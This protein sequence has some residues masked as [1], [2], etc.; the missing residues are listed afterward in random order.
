MK[1][2]SCFV[3]VSFL[4]TTLSCFGQNTLKNRSD[5][6]QYQ[7]AKD[8]IKKEKY[9][10]A[11]P[12]FVDIAKNNLSETTRKE[13]SFY[14][15]LCALQLE[16]PNA[17]DL[18]L[19]FLKKSPND[20]LANRA[21]YELGTHYYRKQKYEKTIKYLSETDFSF[22]DKQDSYEVEFSLAYS[23]FITKDLDNA[24]KHFEA[25]KNN[26]H[27]YKYAANYYS[28][29]IKFKKD[30]YNS[31][32]RDLK[33]AEE[34]G[35]YKQ[36]VPYMIANI[37][38]KQKNYKTLVDYT[39]PII[40]SNDKVSAKAEIVELTAESYF[41]MKDY[42]KAATYF[43]AY[44]GTKKSADKEINYRAGYANLKDGKTQKSID[45]FKE[46]ADAKDSLGQYAS[47]Y[48]GQAYIAE[49]NKVYA[50]AAL[51]EASKSTF[52]LGIREAALFDVARLNYELEQFDKAIKA[53][54]EFDK[55]FP[56]SVRKEKSQEL[57]SDAFVYSNN[58]N[59]ALVYLEA[60]TSLTPKM[61]ENYQHVAYLKAV[62]LY[63]KRAFDQAVV[64]F[65]KSLKYPIN[66]NIEAECQYLQGETYSFNHNWQAAINA[67]AKVFQ[68]TS[69]QSSLF[70]KSRYGIGY[71]YF[72][73]NEYKKAKDH[74]AKFL[75]SSEAKTTKMYGDAFLRLGDCYYFEKNYDEAIKQYNAAIDRK[76]AGADY[77]F[78]QLG[79]VYAISDKLE[80][81]DESFAFLEKNF[82]QSPYR[83][84]ASYNRAR[85]AFE[86]GKYE[87]AEILYTSYINKYSSDKMYSV[88]L[89]KRGKTYFN[90]G[91]FQKSLADYDLLLDDFCQEEVAQ[92][93]LSGA[94]QALS[95]LSRS[96][97][98]DSRLN[99]FETCNP[100]NESIEKIRFE[101]AE[102]NYRALENELAASKFSRFLKNYPNSSYKN[103]AIYYLADAYY[104]VKKYDSSAFYYEKVK[105]TGSK[106]NYEKSLIR[107]SKMYLDLS[108]YKKAKINAEQ[109]LA[110]ATNRRKQA[111]ALTVLVNATYQLASYDSTMLYANRV[112][113]DPSIPSYI[114][115]EA[116]LFAAKVSYQRDSLTQATDEFLHIV[117][118][119]ADE[120]GAEANYYLGKILHQQK[121]YRQSIEVLYEVNKNFS[122][123]Q[124]WVGKSFL[125]IADNDIELKELFQAK[126]IL[127]SLIDN[128]PIK[129]VVETAKKKLKT[130]DDIQSNAQ[131][132]ETQKVLQIDLNAPE[133]KAIQAI[134]SINVETE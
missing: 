19:N 10:S 39:E 131:K 75:A 42:S 123:Y 115:T 51:T 129:E 71:A 80:K 108:N 14:V 77:A 106:D 78:Y 68:L 15:A 92:S 97:E 29:Y 127:Q 2:I 118:S 9:A 12:L 45:Y 41:L 27:K 53:F 26:D 85:V 84:K 87:K 64:Y 117:N 109:L 103:Q 133:D 47:Y 130:I 55:L 100:A 50:L 57:L 49:N 114:K 99:K 3:F 34:N 1:K 24:E 30:N 105:T 33:I 17:E 81:S 4:W 60:Q 21:Y 101:A 119:S 132:G 102:V 93:A 113:N 32:I 128:S 59:E 23:Y 63:N 5:V 37:Y 107:L 44:L 20:P 76:I 16:Q 66:K 70:L 52:N 121:K 40:K 69:D 94:Q 67:Y 116:G 31:A 73:S 126:A 65:D 38:Y 124:K 25:V 98:F 82:P 122:S 46:V 120:F 61:K 13:A 6:F 83:V 104:E 134:D 79:L 11:Y 112:L 58:Y 48:L 18:F 89:L 22:L 86:N 54:A 28:G 111:D 91:K 110:V 7:S 43:N 125:L 36:I 74:F 90:L 56:T 95:S 96:N 62:E 88:A 35:V 72:N 8:L